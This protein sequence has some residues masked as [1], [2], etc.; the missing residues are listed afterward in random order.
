M[1]VPIIKITDTVNC[2]TTSTCL[3]MAATRPALKAPF[4]TLTGLKEERYKAG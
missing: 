3:G 1:I 4:K 2:V